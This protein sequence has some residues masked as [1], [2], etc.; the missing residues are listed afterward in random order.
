[1]VAQEIVIN[2]KQQVIKTISKN[3]IYALVKKWS[4]QPYSDNFPRPDLFY[5]LSI[6]RISVRYMYAI[7]DYSY[8]AQ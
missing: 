5:A 7:V 8:A 6:Y 4:C 2:F 3:H 1:M